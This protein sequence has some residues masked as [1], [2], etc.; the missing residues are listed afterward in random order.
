[1]KAPT[2]LTERI[3][4]LADRKQVLCIYPYRDSDKTKITMET[5]NATIAGYGAPGIPLKKLKDALQ[6]ALSLIKQSL[7][8]ETESI[9]VF[10]NS[11]A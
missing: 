9:E 10:Q 1:M 8:G 5:E 4:V 6:T 3:L 2:F 7:R 11:S